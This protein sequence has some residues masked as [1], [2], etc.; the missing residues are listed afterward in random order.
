MNADRKAELLIE[1]YAPHADK[2][3][4]NTLAGASHRNP[5]RTS[6]KRIIDECDAGD[7]LW[8]EPDPENKFDTNAVKVTNLYD[9]Q[10]GFLQA[11]TAA[12]VS[13]DPISGR[14]GWVC[15]LAH[16]NLHPETFKVVGA[17]LLLIRLTP[18]ATALG[19]N[20]FKKAEVK[21][22]ATEPLQDEAKLI[23]P[24]PMAPEVMATKND[25]RVNP[26][27]RWIMKIFG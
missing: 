13:R 17:T 8:L 7:R 4:F 23:Q 26:L 24:V 14:I 16:H 15:F 22:G 5:D 10:L 2:Y 1:K 11:R 18:E 20:L 12:E 19:S 27:R 21:V 3:F 9:E 6:R 25:V